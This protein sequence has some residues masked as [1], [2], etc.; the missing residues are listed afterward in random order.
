MAPQT[1]RRRPR[2]PDSDARRAALE[3]AAKLVDDRAETA[4]RLGLPVVWDNLV[5]AAKLIRALAEQPAKE[6]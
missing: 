5:Y 3:E 2:P 6:R 1:T 4:L